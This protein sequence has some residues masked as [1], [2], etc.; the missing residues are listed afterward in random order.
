MSSTV[1]NDDRAYRA[2]CKNKS[3]ILSVARNANAR[4][5]EIK[6]DQ[7]FAASH[8]RDI[9]KFLVGRP[10]L[11][12]T[13]NGLV[14]RDA[15]RAMFSAYP[16][17]IAHWA[18]LHT[19]ANVEFDPSP[20]VFNQFYGLSDYGRIHGPNYAVLTGSQAIAL[21]ARGCS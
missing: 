15:T 11:E 7:T 16:S 10:L 4:R 14:R 6:F 17:A 18:M 1:R 13:A 5:D 19:N 8:L 9:D 20:S 3:A 2:F 21:G 12:H